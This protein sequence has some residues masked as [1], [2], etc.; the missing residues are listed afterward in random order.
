MTTCACSDRTQVYYLQCV[1]HSVHPQALLGVASPI[2]RY[3]YRTGILQQK[4]IFRKKNAPEGTPLPAGR[5]TK[6][7][8][9]C[10]P[11][12]DSIE[13]ALLPYICCA[14]DAIMPQYLRIL[15]CSMPYVRQRKITL[16]SYILYIHIA[17]QSLVL[18]IVVS[19]HT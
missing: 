9:T 6:R 15:L 11:T 16:C 12:R 13:A 4:G 7:Y 8:V 14:C 5:S 19:G 17:W 18:S 10:D 2:F 3:S 1:C